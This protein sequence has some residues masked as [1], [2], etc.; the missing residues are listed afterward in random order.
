MIMSTRWEVQKLRDECPDTDP[1]LDPAGS[2][3]QL[4]QADERHEG[5]AGSFTR[6]EDVSADSGPI[7]QLLFQAISVMFFLGCCF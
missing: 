2:H 6:G 1:P 4:P 3:A 5:I 7:W